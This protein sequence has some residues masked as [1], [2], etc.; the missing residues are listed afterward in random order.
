MGDMS[1]FTFECP[2]CEVTFRADESAME[3]TCPHCHHVIRLMDDSTSVSEGSV[4]GKQSQV[5]MFVTQVKPAA[6]LLPP[7]F[8][9]RENIENEDEAPVAPP[10]ITATKEQAEMP[11]A[12]SEEATLPA[13]QGDGGERLADVEVVNTGEPIVEE[14]SGDLTVET[15]SSAQQVESRLQQETEQE[16]AATLAELTAFAEELS[17]SGFLPE[18]VDGEAG[19]PS[20]KIALPPPVIGTVETEKPRPMKSVS[21]KV[22]DEPRTVGHGADKIELLSRTPDEKLQFRRNKNIIIWTIGA[23]LILL[24]MLVM[25]NFT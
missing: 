12:A 5:E 16:I 7:R 19:E 18:T 3:V 13:L 17:D 6:P 24:T 2:V 9:R 14:L 10:V 23:L 22:M 1:L 11:Q 21:I 8:D 20:E 15:L 4:D 25:L